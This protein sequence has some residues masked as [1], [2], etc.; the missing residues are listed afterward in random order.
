[1]AM[2][3]GACQHGWMQPR[4]P[5]HARFLCTA[6]P[7]HVPSPPGRPRMCSRRTQSSVHSLLELG[8]D[9]S[10]TEFV[11]PRR[12]YTTAY[13][14]IVSLLQYR[15]YSKRRFRRALPPARAVWAC[16]PARDT[17]RVQDPSL[18]KP[19]I[20]SGGPANCWASSRGSRA[21]SPISA[22]IASEKRASAPP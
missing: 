9:L 19:P 21:S 12:S 20:L 14:H 3:D 6:R 2:E 5:Y 13:G 18:W 4:R 16:M 22:R 7:L 11:K 1:M 8:R 10:G 17:K 15:S